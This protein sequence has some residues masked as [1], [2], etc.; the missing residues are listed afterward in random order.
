MC[1]LCQL[2]GLLNHGSCCHQEPYLGLFLE[3]E[4]YAAVTLSF[5]SLV[6]FVTSSEGKE[7][8][9]VRIADKKEVLFVAPYA[10]LLRR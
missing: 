4:E 7:K 6:K 9:A 3:C 2:Y 1:F 8:T 5:L 10:S